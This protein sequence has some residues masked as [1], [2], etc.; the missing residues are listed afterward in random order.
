MERDYRKAIELNPNNANAHHEF[1]YL[2]DAMGRL[3]E[4]LTEF[5]VAQE[6]DPNHDHL[7]WALEDRREF[8]R[9]IDIKLMMLRNDPDNAVLHE[10]LYFDYEAKGMY[11]DAV[12]H[13]GRAI[14]LVGFPQIAVALDK[15]FAISGYRG[16]MR[17]YARQFEHLHA[18]KQIFFPVNLAG[19]YATL[20]DKIA[21]F[22]GWSRPIDIAVA[23]VFP[24]G[25]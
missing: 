21:P 5:Q 13:A 7:S 16:A 18:T 15:A 23:Q 25:Q 9:A 11:K 4:G 19:V 12:Y 17:E 3:D 24:S 20:G 6:L 8:D 1:A 22:T 10:D 2:L 14:A